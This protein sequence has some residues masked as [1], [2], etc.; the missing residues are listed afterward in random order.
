MSDVG[1]RGPGRAE[2]DVYSSAEVGIRDVHEWVCNCAGACVGPGAIAFI[3]DGVHLHLIARVGSQS[4]ER[5]AGAGD[6]LRFFREG[7]G[8]AS[9]IPDLV[10]CDS[11]FPGVSRCRPSYRELQIGCM[12]CHR[13][14]GRFGGRLIH[15]RDG[16]RERFADRQLPCAGAACRRDG[17]NI[18][19]VACGISGRGALHVRRILIVGCGAEG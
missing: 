18:F 12:G 5:C 14:C 9:A 16:N 15:I 10:A 3:V 7:P 4:G 8:G 17:N 6:C 1:V 13:G 19:S 11:W 2:V